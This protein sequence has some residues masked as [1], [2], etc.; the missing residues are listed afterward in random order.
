MHR[1]PLKRLVK[2]RPSKG[3][4]RWDSY[5]RLPFQSHKHGTARSWEHGGKISDFNEE[6]SYTCGALVYV[7]RFKDIY[8]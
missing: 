3:V 6:V 7:W 1:S 8:I 5:A 4:A 2:K